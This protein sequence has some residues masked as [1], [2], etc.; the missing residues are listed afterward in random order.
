MKTNYLYQAISSGLADDGAEEDENAPEFRSL[1]WKKDG[2]EIGEALV[3]E[4]V[5]LFCEVKNIDDGETVKF[6]I[7]EQG[8]NKDDPI[9]EVQG[10]VKDGKVTAQWEV[11]NSGISDNDNIVCLKLYYF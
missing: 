6:K 2:K 4:E 1:V 10:T 7:F 8:E 5:V 3:D 9:D 11:A